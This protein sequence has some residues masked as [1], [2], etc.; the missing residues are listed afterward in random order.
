MNING[1]RLCT[2]MPSYPN[3]NV[4]YKNK[5]VPRPSYY[6]ENVSTRKNVLYIE[7][8]TMLKANISIR[9]LDQSLSSLLNQW[10]SKRLEYLQ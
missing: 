8:F 6:D 5:T 4:H 7:T 10:L 9:V 1:W 2:N 3:M